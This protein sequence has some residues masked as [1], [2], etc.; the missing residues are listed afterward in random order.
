MTSSLEQTEEGSFPTS[1]LLNDIGGLVF[2]CLDE[3][4]SL[5]KAIELEVDTVKLG[6]FLI[7]A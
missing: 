7:S 6:S 1:V 5:F 4:P 2:Q 3:D